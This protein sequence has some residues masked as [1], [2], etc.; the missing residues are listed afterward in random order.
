MQQNQ[1]P[2]GWDETKI[3]ELIEYHERQ[4]ANPSSATEE[5]EDSGTEPLSLPAIVADIHALQKELEAF[6]QLYGVLSAT[7]Y[8][9]YLQDE[10][11]INTD[12]ALDWAEWAMTYRTWLRRQAEYQFALQAFRTQVPSLSDVIQQTAD[13]SSMLQPMHV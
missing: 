2:P 10:E 11:P 4:I 9:A 12:W 7:F 13:H 3:R 6:E 1:F 8:E 5:W